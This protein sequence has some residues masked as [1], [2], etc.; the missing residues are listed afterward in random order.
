MSVE[1]KAESRSRQAED[2]ERNASELLKT[3][4]KC[5]DDVKTEESSLTQE[6]RVGLLILMEWT[7]P[8]GMTYRALGYRSNA[9]GAWV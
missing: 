1:E 8:H 3:C 2:K 6:E 5:L 9:S 7:A 4:R